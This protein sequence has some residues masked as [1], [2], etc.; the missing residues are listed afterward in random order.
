MVTDSVAYR[1]ATS[2]RAA[3]RAACGDGS[4]VGESDTLKHF[5]VLR[6]SQETPLIESAV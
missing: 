5:E 6:E 3:T 2:L 1:G 4:D